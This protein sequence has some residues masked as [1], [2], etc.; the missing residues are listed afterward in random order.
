MG[1]HGVIAKYK[2]D[3]TWTQELSKI[4][5]LFIYDKFNPEAELYLPNLPT[6]SRQ[7]FRGANHAN[8]P[9]GRESHT[10]LYHILKHYP[11]FAP[12]TLFSQGRVQDHLPG[13]MPLIQVLISNGVDM[14]FVHFGNLNLCNN[15]GSS[16]HHGLPIKAI[17]ERLFDAPCPEYFLHHLNAC[18]MVR[19]ENLLARP[20]VF[21]EQM[22]QII[23][24]E[25]LA[26]YVFERLWEFVLQVPGFPSKK[27]YEPVKKNDWGLPQL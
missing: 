8:T 22:M 20:R 18:F 2:E 27:Q 5:T 12:W 4:F 9:T 21:Y 25:P 3:V 15:Q 11:N 1:A 19:R 10:Y 17:F 6:F 14:P 26:G 16:R 23:Y 13:F 24:D 7:S